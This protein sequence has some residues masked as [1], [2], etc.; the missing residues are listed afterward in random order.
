M[1]VLRTA[2]VE[3]AWPTQQE[4]ESFSERLRSSD[5]YYRRCLMIIRPL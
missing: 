3:A 4:I 2:S 1:P 5:R